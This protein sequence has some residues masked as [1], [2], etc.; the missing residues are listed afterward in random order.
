LGFI[1]E[2]GF[3]RPVGLYQL[4]SVA[5]QKVAD[6]EDAK[7]MTKVWRSNLETGLPRFDRTAMRY[8]SFG[9]SRR[10]RMRGGKIYLDKT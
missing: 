4:L 9:F 1:L 2:K 5:G 6:Y 8:L 10:A 3:T 7:K